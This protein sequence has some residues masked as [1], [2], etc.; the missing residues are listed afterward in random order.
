MVDK[1]LPTLEITVDIFSGRENPSWVLTEQQTK[2]FFE[3]PQWHEMMVSETVARN[4]GFG[5]NGFIVRN[6]T[7]DI[8][9]LPHRFYLVNTFHPQYNLDN[10][11]TKLTPE[12]MAEREEWLMNTS[13]LPKDYDDLWPFLLD[14]IRKKITTDESTKNSTTVSK[15][16]DPDADAG[17]TQLKTQYKPWEWSNQTDIVLYNNCYNYGVNHVSWGPPAGHAPRGGAQPGRISG[18]QVTFPFT[19]A[20]TKAAAM[21]DGMIEKANC[22]GGTTYYNIALVIAPPQLIRGKQAGDYHWYRQQLDGNTPMWGHKRGQTRAIDF[23]ASRKTIDNTNP[24]E[25][26]NRDYRTTGR[27]GLNYS[28]WC[29]YYYW[30]KGKIVR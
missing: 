9:E 22:Q 24:P 11:L 16:E 25:T 18:H 10:L 23:D 20:N 29:G 13:G 6:L 8:S 15:T 7:P 30:P 26:C 1:I 28:A 21:S 5:F 27:G 19:C 14:A 2:E 3:F 4:F 12:E 17:C